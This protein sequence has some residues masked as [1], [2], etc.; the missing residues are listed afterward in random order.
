MVTRAE[1]QQSL[2]HIIAV[3]I[4]AGA[5][6]RPEVLQHLDRIYARLTESETELEY[7]L[8]YYDLET[9]EQEFVSPLSQEAARRAAEHY[10][11]H[12]PHGARVE[13][14]RRPVMDWERTD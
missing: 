1:A 7:G 6:E 12:P 2:G 10:E 9:G 4:G 8:A 3:L 13:L 14:V 11:N 5:Y